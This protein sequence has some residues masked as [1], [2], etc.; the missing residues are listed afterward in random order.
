MVQERIQKIENSVE[1]QKAGVG[2]LTKVDS[3][4][5]IIKDSDHDHE[6]GDIRFQI[7]SSGT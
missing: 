5:T 6:P 4:I 7:T 1:V 3:N 2:L